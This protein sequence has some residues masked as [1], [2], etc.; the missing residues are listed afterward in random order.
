M[1][2]CGGYRLFFYLTSPV[3]DVEKNHRVR[4]LVIASDASEGRKTQRRVRMAKKA[5]KADKK[6]G[7]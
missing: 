3:A 6:K 7:K 1:P 2:V 4:R 5:K